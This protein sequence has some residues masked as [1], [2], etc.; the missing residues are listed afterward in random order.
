MIERWKSYNCTFKVA[1]IARK[2]NLL[3]IQYTKANSV[4]YQQK[5]V[6][7]PGGQNYHILMRQLLLFFKFIEILELSKDL[8][9]KLEF[10]HI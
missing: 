6:I 10:S 2:L 7:H 9:V 8:L 5:N 3:E 4:T 1:K